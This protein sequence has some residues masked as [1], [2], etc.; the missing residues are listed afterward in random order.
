MSYAFEKFKKCTKASIL[1]IVIISR[2]LV[3]VR[4]IVCVTKIKQIWVLLAFFSK[5]RYFDS[6][7]CEKG[8]K[9]SAGTLS[10]MDAI[11]WR[12]TVKRQGYFTMKQPKNTGVVTSDLSLFQHVLNQ[13]MTIINANMGIR[14]RNPNVQDMCDRLEILE[15]AINRIWQDELITYDDGV[16]FVEN[17]QA[18]LD[19]CEQWFKPVVCRKAT[20]LLDAAYEVLAGIPLPFLTTEQ[21]TEI[22][23]D[24]NC[25]TPTVCRF[26]ERCVGH[27]Y[28]GGSSDE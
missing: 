5:S 24:R 17:S 25:E 3:T 12:I 14:Y 13:L 7:P 22:I 4:T 19:V 27:C 15:A 18:I 8:K 10:L 1:Q 6:K 9:P 20:S 2:F 11:R 26:M 28:T 23:S 21:V 16:N